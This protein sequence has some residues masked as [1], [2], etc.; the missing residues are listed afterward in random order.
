[1]NNKVYIAYRDKQSNL[2]VVY[3]D[4]KLL[5]LEDS[6][7]IRYSYATVEWGYGGEG[8]TQTSIAILFDCLQDEKLVNQFY[9]DFRADFIAS[10]D[11]TGFIILE[12]Q[13]RNWLEQKLRQ[14]G[15]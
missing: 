11:Y 4:G 9:S 15:G 2:P 5:S 8:P 7:K 3:A 12:V 6:Y 10:A 1:M 13:I 14:E